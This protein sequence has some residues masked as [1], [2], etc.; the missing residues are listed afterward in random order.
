M[1]L[2]LR[3]SSTRS[4]WSGAITTTTL[5]TAMISSQMCVP[6]EERV[7]DRNGLDGSGPVCSIMHR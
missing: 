5:V 7:Q 1:L 4:T 2:L 6:G 3:W